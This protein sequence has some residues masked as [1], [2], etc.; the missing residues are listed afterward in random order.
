MIAEDRV[1]E[2]PGERGGP[3]G[4]VAA[5]GAGRDGDV[6]HPRSPSCK[7][8][9]RPTHEG[10][11][12]RLTCVAA[13]HLVRVRPGSASA[14]CR[15][16]LTTPITRP[17]A[18]CSMDT[19]ARRA[20]GLSRISRWPGESS[21]RST[22]TSGVSPTPRTRVSPAQ[23]L[24]HLR[25]TSFWS[26]CSKTP[27]RAMRWPHSSA[28]WSVHDV[29]VPDLAQAVGGAR[30]VDL[31][32]QRVLEDVARHASPSTSATAIACARSAAPTRSC[33]PRP[34]RRQRRTAQRGRRRR[35][36]RAGR[37]SGGGA[38]AFLQ[39]EIHERG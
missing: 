4:G 2:D 12:D 25:M 8:D 33:R 10:A 23:E 26:R 22:M 16:R 7:I 1:G 37:A 38:R 13:A 28:S 5:E 17:W 3:V 36:S 14:V 11:G 32:H 39:G 27:V 21:Q 35:A 6:Q 18:S 34:A 24:L 9:P 20:R 31:H 19:P 29:E 30:G 15:T